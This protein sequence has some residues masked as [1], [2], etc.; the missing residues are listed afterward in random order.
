MPC[1][2]EIEFEGGRISPLQEFDQIAGV[3]GE[4]TDEEGFIYPED[5]PIIKAR[6][7]NSLA[8]MFSFERQVPFFQYVFASHVLRVHDYDVDMR[9][10]I[11]PFL[12][13]LLAY[14]FGVRLQFCRWWLDG[15]I[16]V[17]SMH[18]IITTKETVESFLS[19][20]HQVWK[21][22]SPEDRRLITNILF[23]HSRAPSYEWDWERFTIE[24]MVVDGCW[25]LAA[26]RY[27]L[28]NYRHE[29]RISRLCHQFGIPVEDGLVKDIVE[30]RND[31]FH[32]TL[33]NKSQPCVASSGPGLAASLHIRRLNHRLIPAVLG[34][35]S[36]YVSTPWWIMGTF[37]F[38]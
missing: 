22:W 34:Y 18:N 1:K 23:M 27:R 14:I 28:P 7:P 15:R 11:G 31:L 4:Y 17:K 32:E 35:E 16:P 9:E 33:W 30:L 6:L 25:R 19:H 24:Y 36:E 12:I 29:E 3:I 38:A 13:H 2:W 8:D 21:D 20:C 5:G 26:Q 10:G 37:Y